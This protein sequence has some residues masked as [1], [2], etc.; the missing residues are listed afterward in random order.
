MAHTLYPRGTVKKI[1]KAHSNR[2]LSRDVDILVR[3][4]LFVALLCCSSWFVVCSSSA[5]NCAA[6]GWMRRC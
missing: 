3:F 6:D 1:V 2:A 4:V 5:G